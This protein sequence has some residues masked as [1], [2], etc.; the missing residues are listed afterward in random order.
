M[1][2]E[3]TKGQLGGLA[4]KGRAGIQEGK[5][6]QGRNGSSRWPGHKVA[7]LPR[8]SLPPRELPTPPPGVPVTGRAAAAHAPP[9]DPFQYMPG[10]RFVHDCTCDNAGAGRRSGGAAAAAPVSGL[11]APF[12][13]LLSQA[14]LAKIEPCRRPPF[15][16]ASYWLE[17]EDFR[18]PSRSRSRPERLSAA[19]LHPMRPRLPP[20][21]LQFSVVREASV[22]EVVGSRK[23]GQLRPRNFFT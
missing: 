10:P 13:W 20:C 2:P 21:S 8:P 15:T 3:D 23:G 18:L 16:S 6:S 1:C 9:A 7:S 19:I 14:G 4:K 12:P 11:H 22:F 17:T 5:L